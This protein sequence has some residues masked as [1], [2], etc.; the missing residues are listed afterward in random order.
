MKRK[1]TNP[2]REQSFV[3]EN[4]KT[5]DTFPENAFSNLAPDPQ[6]LNPDD[7]GLETYMEENDYNFLPDLRWGIN[8]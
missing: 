5:P 6:P 8:D 4:K 7:P 1:T 2:K 3:S